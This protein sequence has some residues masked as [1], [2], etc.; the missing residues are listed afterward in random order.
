MQVTGFQDIYGQTIS[1]EFVHYL[2]EEQKFSSLDELKNQL[3]LDKKN[4][5]TLLS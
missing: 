3:Q 1:V 5:T 2:R 4:A